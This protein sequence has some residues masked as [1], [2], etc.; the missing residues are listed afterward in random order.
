MLINRFSFMSL[1][2][3]AAKLRKIIDIYKKIC[4]LDADFN[5]FLQ[6]RY[7]LN[8]LLLRSIGFLLVDLGGYCAHVLGVPVVADVAELSRRAIIHTRRIR[9]TEQRH[10]LH[11]SRR[12]DAVHSLNRRLNLRAERKIIDR[13]SQYEHLGFC[14]QR[15]KF[16]HVVFLDARAVAL[17]VAV[18]ARQTAC[19][20]FVRHVHDA[21][22]PA[23]CLCATFTSVTL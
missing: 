15:I 11:F 8:D 6:F 14:H 1:Q 13:S 12:V 16:L 17:A 2:L 21:R 9:R 23:I 22:Q 3:S 19:D 18:L 5:E 4:T 20:M 10:L 7:Q